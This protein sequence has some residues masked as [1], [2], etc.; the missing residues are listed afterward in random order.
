MDLYRRLIQIKLQVFVYCS[1]Y[2]SE[3]ISSPVPIK[4]HLSSLIS[5][6]WS[7]KVKWV[8]HTICIAFNTNTWRQEIPRFV[9]NSSKTNDSWSFLYLNTLLYG[10]NEI[11]LLVCP[12]K[13]ITRDFWFCFFRRKPAFSQSIYCILT[14]LCAF[15]IIT[16]V[17]VKKVVV[18]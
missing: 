11:K 15:F 13:W 6:L 12:L 4:H 9:K 7:F 8:M 1:C 5:V 17:S 18:V 2:S 3:Y 16:T 14:A 10:I